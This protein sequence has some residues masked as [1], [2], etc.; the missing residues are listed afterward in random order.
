MKFVF[1]IAEK[2]NW[3]EELLGPFNHNTKTV[4]KEWFAGF[5]KLG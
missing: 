1:E 3:K 2:K 5:K 4:G